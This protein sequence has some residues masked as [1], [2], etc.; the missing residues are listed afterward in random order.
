[1]SVTRVSRQSADNTANVQDNSGASYSI[2]VNGLVTLALDTTAFD[3]VGKTRYMCF[4]Y[5]TANLTGSWSRVT[6]SL[7]GTRYSRVEGQGTTTINATD[8]YFYVI[9]S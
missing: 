6:P 2:A 4:R 5:T 9:V 7:T 8:S 1:M 3:V